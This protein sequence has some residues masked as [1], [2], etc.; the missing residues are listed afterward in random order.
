[1]KRILATAMAAAALAAMGDTDTEIL[2]E[3]EKNDMET[4]PLPK[5]QTGAERAELRALEKRRANME[6]ERQRTLRLAETANTDDVF[7]NGGEGSDDFPGVLVKGIRVGYWKKIDG[8]FVLF[9]NAA[10]QI[11]SRA[12]QRD[13]KKAAAAL[14]E[15]NTSKRQSSRQVRRRIAR[16]GW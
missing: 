1:M 5:T 16:K 7:F 9:N 3:R 14:Y 12:R 4:K 8:K 10:E 15:G 13:L 6:A 11:T 2:Y